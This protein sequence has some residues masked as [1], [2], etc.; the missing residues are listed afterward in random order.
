MTQDVENK[1]DQNLETDNNQNQNVKDQDNSNVPLNKFL[2]Q[3]KINKELKEK[4]AA[5]EQKEKEV[6]EAKLLE[7]KQYQEL[8]QN[9]AKEAEDLK[10]QLNLERKNNKLEKVK[11]Q[12][13][14][15]LSK[16]NVIDSD[17]ALKLV[18]YDDLLDSDDVSDLI[19][20]RALDLS[21]NKSYLFKSNN[22]SRDKFEN[23]VPN[24]STPQNEDAVKS[25]MD[26]VLA[27]LV[28]KLT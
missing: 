1:T 24:N 21:K 12:F 19:K 22:S 5:F 9:K 20:S 4:L 16:L 10:S 17:D 11:Y 15:E 14:S 27:S 28:S 26:P 2:D 8:I 6:K 18:K 25:K 23:N 7:E 3:K 13:S